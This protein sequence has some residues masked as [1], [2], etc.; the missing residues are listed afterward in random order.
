MYPQ[1]ML[2]FS[3][4]LQIPGRI[5]FHL[6]NR[7]KHCETSLSRVVSWAFNVNCKSISVLSLR[8]VSLVVE[9]L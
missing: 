2:H 1:E 6:H 9:Y 4:T 3:L 8:S 5:W 7:D